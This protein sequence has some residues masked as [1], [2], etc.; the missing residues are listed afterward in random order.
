[1]K[2]PFA[3]VTQLAAPTSHPPQNQPRVPAGFGGRDDRADRPQGVVEIEQQGLRWALCH[4]GK[5]K[6]IPGY[7][8]TE[9]ARTACRVARVPNKLL[10]PWWGLALPNALKYGANPCKMLHPCVLPALFVLEKIL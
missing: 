1:M 8:R 3:P 6:W 7:C 5:N 10:H 4:G 2:P 9:R